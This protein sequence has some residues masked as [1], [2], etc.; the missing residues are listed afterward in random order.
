[1]RKRKRPRNDKGSAVGI[2]MESYSNAIVVS[3]P[4]GKVL[5]F[6]P[7]KDIVVGARSE[8]GHYD[9]RGNLTVTPLEIRPQSGYNPK[10]LGLD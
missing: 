3:K 7:R 1:M 2:D 4:S 5:F 10:E 6:P 9:E 8:H